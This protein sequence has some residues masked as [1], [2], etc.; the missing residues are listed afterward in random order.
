MAVGQKSR[1]GRES[2]ECR[3]DGA[4]RDP[5]AGLLLMAVTCAKQK[6][7]LRIMETRSL[8]LAAYLPSLFGAC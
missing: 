1:R 2:I 4:E 5:A 3:V 6:G 8:Y 7:I